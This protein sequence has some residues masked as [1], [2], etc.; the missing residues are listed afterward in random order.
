MVDGRGGMGFP[1]GGEGFEDGI[2]NLAAV[3]GSL[4]PLVEVSHISKAVKAIA[5]FRTCRA[6]ECWKHH[7][8][9]D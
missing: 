8:T 1:G 4:T 5:A 7:D 9:Y 3:A 6:G 2:L